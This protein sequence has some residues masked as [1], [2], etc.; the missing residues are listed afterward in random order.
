MCH[1][2]ESRSSSEGSCPF[3]NV[4]FHLVATF[5]PLRKE[6]G[7]E[8]QAGNASSQSYKEISVLAKSVSKVNITTRTCGKHSEVARV[9]FNRLRKSKRGLTAMSCPSAWVSRPAW[10]PWHFQQ[11][12]FLDFWLLRT[13]LDLSFSFFPSPCNLKCVKRKN[14]STI[15]VR[16]EMQITCHHQTPVFFSPE[17]SAPRA[18]DQKP[19]CPIISTLGEWGKLYSAL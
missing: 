6:M 11:L 18:T 3:Y 9:A 12:F 13:N 17:S 7:S 14:I 5:R 19:K 4:L 10:S 8:F 1:C 15:V 2:Q 16:N